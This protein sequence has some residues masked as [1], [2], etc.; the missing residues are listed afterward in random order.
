MVSSL[1]APFVFRDR[2]HAGV[3]AAF[4]AVNAIVAI[5][6]SVHDPRIGYDAMDHLSYL[7][8]LAE[9]SWP[10]RADTGQ[11]FAAPLPYAIP[12]ASALIGVHAP[13]TLGQVAQACNLLYALILT[14]FLLRVSRRIRSDDAAC[15]I[16]SLL[17][18]GGI[19]AY[20]RSMAFVRG[21]PLAA[22]LAVV[23]VDCAIAAIVRPRWDKHLAAGAATGLLLLAKQTGLF[24]AVPVLVLI[25]VCGRQGDRRRWAWRETIAAVVVA[26]SICGWFYAYL[27]VT[28][29]SAAKY[30]LEPAGLSLRNR[31]LSFYGGLGLDRLFVSP[32]R[33]EFSA[34][35][36]MFFPLLYSDTWGD[37][38][39]YW[40]VAGRD[41]FGRAW[42]GEMVEDDDGARTNL[43][44]MQPFLAR[45]NIAG[46][47]P[48]LVMGAGTVLGLGRLRHLRGRL[49]P[50]EVALGLVSLAAVTTALGYVALLIWFPDLDIKATSILQL[51][52]FAAV[53][54][55]TWIRELHDRSPR[56]AQ[57]VAAA[58][59]LCLLHN[60]P[61]LFSR[62]GILGGFSG[63]FDIV[64]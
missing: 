51:F 4:V 8:K 26:L 29:G 25:L 18:V 43:D 22:A 7:Q 11:F 34:A 64:S 20:Q 41:Q 42:F 13:I 53:L 12:A 36:M 21:E 37:Y 39:C 40:L 32:V 48:T 15:A 6:I 30:Y 33:E 52:P 28:Y 19:T 38:W 54:G 56:R 49:V 23:A 5:N 63:A 3:L 1:I 9:G 55:A 27:Q 47:L 10:T 61:A 45:A 59:A 31:P 24:V 44:T 17:L 60:L 50:S 2:V 16:W 57:F 14:Y 35:S 46:L 58:L 62:Y